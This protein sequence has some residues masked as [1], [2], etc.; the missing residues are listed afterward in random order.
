MNNNISER[1]SQLSPLKQALVKLEEMQS[2]LKAIEESKTEPIAIIGMGCRFPG[3]A[4]DPETYWQLLRNGVDG[5]TE[6]PTDRWDIEAYYDANPDAPGKMYV[7]SGGFLDRV[8]GFDPQFFGISPREA[9]GIDP[10][11]RLLLEVSWEALEQAG[12]L[13]EKLRGTQTGVFV[14][15]SLDDYSE[16]SVFSGDP[17]LIDAYAALGNFRSVAAGRIAYILGLQG[18]TMQVDTACSSSLL[19]VHLACQSLRSRECNLALAGGVNVMLS[20]GTTIGFCKLRALSADGHC[21]TFDAAADGY[22]RGEG[23]GVVVL[24]RLSDAVTDGDNIQALIRGTAVNHDG[25]SSGL[26]VPN[27]QAQEELI[28][29]ALR[30]GKVEGHQIS[31]IEAH[32][33]GTFLGDPIEMGALATVL[34]QERSP[35]QPLIVGSAKTN[36]GHLEAAAGI[37]GL[38]KVV[39]SLQNQEIPPHLHFKQP[40]P[41]IQ[42]NETSIE[43]PTKAIP[44]SVG[45]KPRLAGVSA[46]GFSGTNAHVVLEEAPQSEQLL[47]SKER[48]LHLLTL[49]A[50]T[51]EALK[52]LS[53]KYCE[54]LANKRQ[55]LGDICF[56]A[57]TRRAH[58]S[59][60][61]SVIAAS[62][63]QL[64]EK[65]SAFISGQETIG[66]QPGQVTENSEPKIAFLFTGQ[67]AQYVNMGRQLYETQPTFRQTLN[68]CDEIL[69]SY[70]EKPLLEVLYPKLG[71][72][73]PLNETAYTQPALFALEYSL[74]QLW[75][76]WGIEP[77]VVMGHSVG[78]YVAATVAGVFSLEDGL[79]LIAERGRLM[80]ALPQDGQMVSVLADEQRVAAVI[81]PYSKEVTIAAI[82]GPESIVISGSNQGIEPVLEV[83]EAEGIKTKKLTVSHAFHSPL[84]KPMLEGFEQ[85]AQKV[86][87]STPKISIISNITGSLVTEEICTSEYWCA[88]ILQP[89][90]F[91]ASMETLTQQGYKVMVEIGPKPILLGMGRHCLPEGEGILL[92][93]LRP[94]QQDWQQL[95]DSLVKLYLRG[96]TVNWSG[97]DRDYSRR[98]VV[99]PTYPFQRQRYWLETDNQPRKNSVKLH[100]LLNKK[101]HSPLY[102]TNFF[103]S[104]FSIDDLPFLTDHRVYEKVVV[105]G[106]CHVSLLLSAAKIAFGTE[107]CLLENVLFPQALVIPEEKSRTVQ[108]AITSEEKNA[109]FKLISFDETV[110]F[111]SETDLNS[112]HTD[113]SWAIHATGKI[114]TLTE[115]NTSEAFSIQ[116]MQARCQRTIASAELYQNLWERQIQLGMSF[117]WVDSIWQGEGE[118]LCQMKLPQTV[119]SKE[120]FQL[121]PGLIDS[122]FHLLVATI[123]SDEVHT[124]VPFSIESFRFYHRPNNW[125]LWC[126]AS[127][128]QVE[129]SEVGKL[130]GDIKLFDQ[131]G[132]LIAEVIGFEARNANPEILLSVLQKDVDDWLYKIDWHSQPRQPNSELTPINKPGSWLLFID[133]NGIGIRMAQQLR[134]RG[135]HCVLVSPGEAYK[136]LAPEHYQINPANPEDFQ[137]LLQESLE[138]DRPAY[139]GIVHLWS[140]EKITEQDL[141]LADLQEKQVKSCGSALHLVQALSLAAWSELP[142]LWLVTKGAQPVEA[143]P[144]TLQIQQAP[145]WGLGQVIAQEH[146][147]LHCVCLD[148]DPSEGA[149]AVQN[150]LTELWFLDRE[151]QVAYRQ[152]VRHVARLKHTSIKKVAFSLEKKSVRDDSCYLIVGGLGALGLKIAKWLVKQGARHLVLAGR[153][154]ASEAALEVINILEQAD[155][156]ILVVKVDIS[157]SKD[158]AKLMTAIKDTMPPLRG[159]IQAAGVLDD[160]VLL[161]QT[162][163]R[164][165]WV[166]APKVEGSWNLHTLTQKLPLDFFICFSSGVSLLGAAGQGNYAAANAFIDALAHY[167]QS[168]DLPGLS[169]N[170]GPWANSGMAATLESR[171]RSRM[172]AQGLRMIAP[173]E[174]LEVLDKLLKQDTPQVGVLPVN[175][176]KF[177]QQFP[178]NKVPKFFNALVPASRQSLEPQQQFLQQLEAAPIV[179]RQA[180]LIAHV[181]EQV[182]QVLG[183]NSPEQI[184]LRQRFFDLGIDSLMALDLKNK[185]DLSLGYSLITTLVFDY[186]TVEALVNYLIQEVLSI[187]FSDSSTLKPQKD[188]EENQQMLV[189][190]KQLSESEAETLLLKELENLNY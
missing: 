171:E 94:G 173:K 111:K 155:V 76:S 24:K 152:N 134:E 10:Q 19:S 68:R 13:P 148:L 27:E 77:A 97:F 158:S 89:V 172:A 175:W 75:Q 96:A 106:A 8:D 15:L 32:G 119:D 114:S 165:S 40:N 64:L 125:D 99:L 166:M 34:C 48:P 81:N 123:S 6:V 105:P 132:Q 85:I 188:N 128:R 112:G 11:Q 42:W 174:G 20:P 184:N 28:R 150:L 170:W 25:P 61:L 3:G 9:T 126:H 101:L 39:L 44:W 189:E 107:G 47:S 161:Q 185:L 70:L 177:L 38:I 66:V 37:A 100:P 116:K 190:L 145:L 149:D 102:K 29:Q 122:C 115:S 53:E 41:H 181:R 21:K 141:T 179:E 90:Q 54:H 164:F 180:L 7:R 135:D 156:Q 83:L 92:P 120:E 113:N 12:Q 136:Y 79:K 176:S 117:R 51:D 63:T 137:R 143:T 124:F 56:T 103:E 65:L 17:S 52:Q 87:Y 118:A 129:K 140:L 169:I 82:N 162:W 154:E 153:S 121:H 138:D 108:L 109:S 4:N 78:E 35:Q 151:N 163:A 62:S 157:D 74:A 22:S 80:Q 58:F 23:C 86:T 144:T 1:I 55:S 178:I 98:K 93:S 5:I 73:S 133:Q 91:A 139:R 46:F 49:S 187:E 67:G 33:T 59:H 131:R 84:M 130:I 159:V 31:Y 142:R 43:I 36:I 72:S 147:N 2:K 146:S 88:H 69:R 57:N 160:G 127:C 45:E 26:T 168:L 71:I 16:R 167:R 50:K 60:R 14:G 183:L 95:L 18:P 186:P 110:N 30:N 182:A 104:Y